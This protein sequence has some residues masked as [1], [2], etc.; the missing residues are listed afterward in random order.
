M[1]EINRYRIRKPGEL[2]VQLVDGE[3][4]RATAVEEINFLAWVPDVASL[5]GWQG[6]ALGGANYLDENMPSHLSRGPNA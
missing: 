4:R 5:I 3:T 2:W 1:K 6:P